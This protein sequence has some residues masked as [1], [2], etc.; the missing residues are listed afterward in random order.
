MDIGISFGKEQFHVEI[1]EK[2]IQSILIPQEIPKVDESE[3]L[4]RAIKNPVGT[5]R[6]SEL[7]QSDETVCI[8]TS[9]VT[10]P[11]PTRK[12]LVPVLEE[13]ASAGVPDENICIAFAL[14]AHRKHTL[15]EKKKL[16]G[17]DVLARIQCLDLDMNDC[18]DLGTTRA[19]TPLHVFRPVVEAD[20]RICMGNIEF[21]YFAG[22]SGGA[23]AILPGVSTHAAI[24]SNHKMMLSEKAATGH[25]AGN[26]VRE[27]IDTV[28]E[29]LP[30]DCIFNVV[31]GPHKEILRAVLGDPIL[32]H[33]QGCAFLD[34]IY[35]FPLDEPA[36]IV[37]VSPGGYPKD[38]NIYQAQKALD[39]AAHA[40]RKGG[41]ILWVARC[42]EGYGSE[43]F[44]EWVNDAQ[45][46]Q[47]LIDRVRKK[48]ELGGHK[49]A[50]MAKVRQKADIF[51]LSDLDDAAAE[52]LFCT[53]VPSL[54][55]GL[56]MARER[57]G[58]DAR[59]VVMPHGG[60]TLPVIQGDK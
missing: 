51:L 8:I 47:D 49:A 33:R 37:L 54:E 16:V 56:K 34:T 39:N 44:T 30:I 21:H 17:E 15:E 12:M 14:G 23:K 18:V 9:D 48:F 59:I 43:K 10:R 31:L 42:Q 26:P 35:K 52:N 7:V 22:Y 4:W 60:S 55:K 5:Q 58:Q 2:S 13:L 27:D 20:R 53:P 29:L 19:G 11:C 24:Q 28:P 3:E 36:D 50:A 41:I 40:V 57:L 25:L 38:L 32:A 6:I 46:P 1:E 45:T